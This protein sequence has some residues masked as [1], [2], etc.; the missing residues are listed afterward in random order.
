MTEIDAGEAKAKATG[1]TAKYI[2]G[3][4]VE[5]AKKKAVKAKAKTKPKGKA[6]PKA[7]AE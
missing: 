2:D 6:K 7:K 3:K 5:E 1:W 4:W